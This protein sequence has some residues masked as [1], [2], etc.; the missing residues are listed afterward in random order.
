[1][2]QETSRSM[3]QYKT[4]LSYVA[5][6]GKIVVAPINNTYCIVA[7]LAK[8]YAVYDIERMNLVSRGEEKEAVTCIGV[9]RRYIIT[10][11]ISNKLYISNR[12]RVLLQVD[13]PD[14]PKEITATDQDIFVLT[15]SNTLLKLHIHLKEASLED[16]AAPLYTIH[17]LLPELN[18]TNIHCLQMNNKLLAVS[19]TAIHIYDTHKEAVIYTLACF[20]PEEVKDISSSP[21]P[22]IIAIADKTGV[23]VINIKKDKVLQRFTMKNTLSVDFKRNQSSSKEL[24]IATTTSLVFACLENG[25]VKKTLPL[26]HLSSVRFIGEDDYLA[27]SMKNELRILD[28]HKIDHIVT[29]KKRTGIV[30]GEKAVAAFHNQA[31]ALLTNH[32]LYSISLRKEDQ[33]KEITH[34]ETTGEPVSLAIQKSTLLGCFTGG[35]VAFREKNGDIA[36]LKKKLAHATPRSHLGA[37]LSFCGN[38]VALALEDGPETVRVV[39]ATS[40]AGFILGEIVTPRYHALSINNLTKTLTL[41]LSTTIRSYSFSGEVLSETSMPECMIAHL[42][43]TRTDSYALTGDGTGISVLTGK[44]ELLRRIP[45][46]RGVPYSLRPTKDFKWAVLVS[47]LPP[48]T[49]NTQNTPSVLEIFDIETGKLLSTTYF[50]T[51]PRDCLLSEDKASLVVMTKSSLL[52]YA[53]TRMMASEATE[54]CAVARQG[55]SFSSV[56]KS[57]LRLLLTYDTLAGEQ[58]ENTADQAVPHFMTA[59]N[60]APSQTATTPQDLTINALLDGNYPITS[61]IQYLKTVPDPGKLLTELVSHLEPQYDIVEALINRLVHYR[62]E[63]IDPKELRQVLGRRESLS[64]KFICEYLSLLSLIPK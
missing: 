14:T 29:V 53:N 1:M 49:Q 19:K 58:A 39:V 44:G 38:V 3:F 48:T 28:C 47:K 51:A 60:D 20:K 52:L 36:R 63:D 50:A 46:T 11:C 64:E 9:F 25:I 34:L 33:N 15:G 54:D 23:A 37:E 35:P 2:D 59:E 31:L 18:I 42:V 10:G 41:V 6:K 27:V 24:C 57:R 4:Q 21:A 17:P 32:S 45:C 13:L 40:E 62:R 16:K 8:T 22:E 26:E 5:E 56:H 7:P 12:G 55:L 43:D 30:F 61:I